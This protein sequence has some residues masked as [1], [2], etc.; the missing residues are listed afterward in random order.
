[1]PAKSMLALARSRLARAGLAHCSVRL[2][3][4]YRLPL[5]DASFDIAVLQMVLHHAEQ[6]EAAI[7]RGRPAAA[8]GR[9]A[10]RGR[11]RRRTDAMRSPN[12]WRIAGPGS[13]TTR[14]HRWLAAGGLSPGEKLSIPGCADLPVR[15][16]TATRSEAAAGRAR[17]ELAV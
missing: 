10:D 7:D 5:A 15:I 6:P 16:W 13:A 14:M 4:M 3:D 9:A 1:M 12:G 2:A 11:S 17:A 8:P